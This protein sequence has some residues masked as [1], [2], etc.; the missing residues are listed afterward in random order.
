MKMN[1]ITIIRAN[2]MNSIIEIY[3]EYFS[4]L[5]IS[6]IQVEIGNEA[7]I[8]KNSASTKDVL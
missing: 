8:P 2:P 7:N 6:L 1:E 3:I 5:K 4:M